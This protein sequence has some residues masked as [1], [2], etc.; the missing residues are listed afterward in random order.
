MWQA[1]QVIFIFFI[2][3]PKMSSQSQD[4]KYGLWIGHMHG[5]G[6]GRDWARIGHERTR[7][8]RA[9]HGRT[10][11]ELGTGGLGTGELGTGGLCPNVMGTH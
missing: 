1:S 4:C 3:L 2:K 7:H 10:G 9:R 11:H 5:H 6:H 8:G